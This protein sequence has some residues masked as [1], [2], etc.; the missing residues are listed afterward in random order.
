M[1]ITDAALP[2]WTFQVEEVSAGVYSVTGKDRAGRAVEKKGIDPD[3]LIAEC[4]QAAI[5]MLQ[6]KAECPSQ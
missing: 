4:K 6:H 2:G 5:E 3:V 1:A